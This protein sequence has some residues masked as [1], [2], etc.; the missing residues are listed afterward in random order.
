M[1]E[2]RHHEA[3]SDQDRW[4]DHRLMD[5]VQIEKTGENFRILY[6]VKGRFTVHRYRILFL[7]VTFCWPF[8]EGDLKTFKFWKFC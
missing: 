2:G 4:K 5:V 7:Q 3:A 8:W 6:D 1:V